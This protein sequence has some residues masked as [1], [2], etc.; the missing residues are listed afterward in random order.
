MWVNSWCSNGRNPESVDLIGM[1]WVAATSGLSRTMAPPWKRPRV[2]A[3]RVLQF[4]RDRRA[5][6]ATLAASGKAMVDNEP[7]NTWKR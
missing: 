5:I 4:D 2:V 7:S 6:A 1:V 3:Q